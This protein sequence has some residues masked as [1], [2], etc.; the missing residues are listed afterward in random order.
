MSLHVHETSDHHITRCLHDH[1]QSKRPDGNM[2]MRFEMPDAVPQEMTLEERLELLLSDMKERSRGRGFGFG[3]G[4]DVEKEADGSGS[5]KALLYTPLANSINAEDKRSAINQELTTSAFI[6]A[7]K[8]RLQGHSSR[9]GYVKKQKQRNRSS[10]DDHKEGKKANANAM[11]EGRRKRRP[12][13]WLNV[14]EPP[15]DEK[16]NGVNTPPINVSDCVYLTGVYDKNGLFR[17]VTG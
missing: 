10:A 13:A 2:G 9:S 12:G 14:D 15:F 11:S 16:G 6:G 4:G 8:E 5:G 7:S 1:S 3:Y 17:T